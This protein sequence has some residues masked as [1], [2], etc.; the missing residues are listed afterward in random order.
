MVLVHEVKRESRVT[1]GMEKEKVLNMAR[2]VLR[3]T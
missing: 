2:E 1:N 3:I